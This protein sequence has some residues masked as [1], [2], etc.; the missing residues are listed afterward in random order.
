M[1]LTAVSAACYIEVVILVLLLPA[2]KA[3]DVVLSEVDVVLR[4]LHRFVGVATIASKRS[5]FLAKSPIDPNYWAVLDGP[6]AG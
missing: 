1:R 5:A 3:F 2:W 4:E 6:L